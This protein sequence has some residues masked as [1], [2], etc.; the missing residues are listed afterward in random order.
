MRVHRWQPLAEQRDL[1]TGLLCLHVGKKL[2]MQKILCLGTKRSIQQDKN[3]VPATILRDVREI[4]QDRR[5]L[6]L[7]EEAKQDSEYPTL[8]E[9]A[10]H[11]TGLEEYLHG[12]ILVL[13]K[14]AQKA[15]LNFSRIL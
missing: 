3:V 10:S 2:L 6:I 15:L 5:R 14:S 12:E 4:T 1:L 8:T 11:I 7:R 9:A 13:G